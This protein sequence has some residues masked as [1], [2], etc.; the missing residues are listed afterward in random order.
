MPHNAAIFFV[1]RN[2]ELGRGDRIAICHADGEVSYASLA[3]AVSQAGHWLLRH[4]VRPEQRVVILLNDGPEFFFIFLAALK[5]GAVAVPV[6]TFCRP[7]VLA[8]YLND[9]RAPI[10]VTHRANREKVEQACRQMESSPPEVA[11]VDDQEWRH[12]SQQL[13]TFPVCADDSA[14]WLYTSGSTGPQKGV[15]H[16]HGGMV[17]CAQ[18]YGRTILKIRDHDR[19]FSTSKLFFAYGLGNSL[20]FP[21]AVGAS[22]VVND[23]RNDCETVVSLVQ[24]YRPT[25]FFS[26]PALYQHLLACPTVNREAFSSVR[27]CISAGEYLAVSTSDAWQART[28]I[29]PCDGIGSTEAMHIFCSNRDGAQRPGTSGSPVDGYELKIV[30]DLGHEVGEDEVGRL[31]VRGKTLATGYWN[32]HNATQRSFQGEWLA[33]GDIYRRSPDGFYQ[34]VGRQDDVFKSHGLWVSSSEI[35]Q[36]LLSH[37]QIKEAAVVASQNSS[38][39]FVARA[40]VAPAD[41]AS[42]SEPDD[43]RREIYAY[44]Y[45][46]L[47]K[48][49]LPDSIAILPILPKTA[50]GKIARAELRQMP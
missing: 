40:F 29:V 24:R 46:R 48:Y 33:T 12:E 19:C 4:G 36:V 39:M 38:G 27:M 20:I 5:I 7:D 23:G 30:D 32:K 43:L 1:D 17:Q 10:V 15:V 11:Y 9:A 44:L 47:S 6:N 8:Y 18:L 26:V 42:V 2:L 37:E 41:G 50:T 45:G 21:F 34:Y 16:R 49:K 31:M 14:F 3:S 28:G 13:E 35:E 25:L 22:C